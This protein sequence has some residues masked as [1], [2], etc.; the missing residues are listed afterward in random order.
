MNP[1]DF[2]NTLWQSYFLMGFVLIS[3]LLFTPNVIKLNKACQ[4]N[5]AINQPYIVMI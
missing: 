5:P 2:E 4:R 3:E 1:R